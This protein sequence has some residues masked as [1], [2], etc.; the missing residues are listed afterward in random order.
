MRREEFKMERPGLVQI[1]QDLQIKEGRLPNS[2]YY[3]V[4]HAYAMS[5]NYPTVKRIKST[6]GIV[7]D[8]KE[9]DRGYFITLEFDE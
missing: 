8:I 4:E 5:G 1:G 9:T 2:Y 6:H 3:T 7:V